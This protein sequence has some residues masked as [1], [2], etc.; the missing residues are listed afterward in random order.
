MVGFPALLASVAV[1]GKASLHLD[2]GSC[3]SFLVHSCSDG[4]GGCFP[5]PQLVCQLEVA[6]DWMSY[7]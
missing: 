1:G 2:Q 4:D 7:C 6:S 3:C 5:A